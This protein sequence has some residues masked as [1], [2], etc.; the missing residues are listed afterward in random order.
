MKASKIES[1]EREKKEETKIQRNSS[2]EET[3][4][5]FFQ[6]QF[7]RIQGICDEY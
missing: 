4:G 7:N 1:N 5:K 6:K 2:T 3:Y